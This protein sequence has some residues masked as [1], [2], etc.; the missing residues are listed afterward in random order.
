MT[1]VFNGFGCASM[2]HASLVGALVEPTPPAVVA[3]I[4]EDL[5]RAIGALE[6]KQWR[7]AGA[8]SYRQHRHQPSP[9]SL[10]LLLLSLLFALMMSSS[11]SSSLSSSSAPTITTSEI[12]KARSRLEEEVAFLVNLVGD[13][14]DDVREMRSSSLLALE[15]RTATVE[16]SQSAHEGIAAPRGGD[17]II[18]PEQYERFSCMTSLVLAAA[19]ASSQVRSFF[20]VVGKLGRRFRVTSPFYCRKSLPSSTTP[21]AAGGGGGEARAGAP[22]KTRPCWG[23]P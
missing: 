10:L 7:L 1:L 16:P 12:C 21:R 13:M 4:G 5:D 11:L 17:Y 19:L 9:T 2:P 22:T 14:E 3:K 15:A 23:Q 6:E 20:R 18:G 8:M